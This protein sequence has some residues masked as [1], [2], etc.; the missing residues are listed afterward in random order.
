MLGSSA[1]GRLCNQADLQGHVDTTA[2]IISKKPDGDSIRYNFK[3]TDSNQLP[4]IIEKGYVTIDGASL[5]VT[6]V[7]DKEASFGIML[8]SHSQSILTL[9]HKEVSHALAFAHKRADEYQIG[10]TVNIEVDVVGKYVLGSTDRL[11]AM[12]NKM[13]DQRL[14][15]RGL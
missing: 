12:V 1:V 13:V 11:E 7:D 6:E 5:T 10:H 9:T 8:I 15:E 4:Y 14:K 2:S 3:L